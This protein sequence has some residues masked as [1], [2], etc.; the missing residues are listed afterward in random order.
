[1]LIILHV[2]TA[3]TSM[4]IAAYAFFRTS[5]QMLRVNYTFVALTVI[6]GTYLTFVSPAHILKTCLVGLI[7]LIAV[8]CMLIAARYKL[9]DSSI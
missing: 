8:T 6:S 3:L 9:A 5:Q 1:M 7:Y 4:G 2:I